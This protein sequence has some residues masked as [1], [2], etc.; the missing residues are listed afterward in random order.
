ML[1]EGLVEIGDGIDTAKASS[2][3][4]GILGG[5]A[6][7]WLVLTKSLAEIVRMPER[8]GVVYSHCGT[9]GVVGVEN[10]DVGLFRVWVLLVLSS[11][12]LDCARILGALGAIW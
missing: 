6:A 9:V 4:S 10:G 11:P 7:G 8:R 12:R 3:V 2:S 1:N 5:G